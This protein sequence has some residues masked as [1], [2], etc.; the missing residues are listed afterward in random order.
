MT[1]DRLSAPG[2]NYPAPVSVERHRAIQIA[3]RILNQA[4]HGQAVDTTNE[5]LVIL[6]HSF[7]RHLGVSEC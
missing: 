6:S 1:N 2:C 3:K 5:E 4:E 7:L